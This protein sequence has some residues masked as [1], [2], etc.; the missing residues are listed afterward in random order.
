MFQRFFD[1]PSSKRDENVIFF[2]GSNH[3]FLTF[4]CA[5]G[6][7]RTLPVLGIYLPMVEMSTRWITIIV[8][9]SHCAA[10]RSL[11]SLIFKRYKKYENKATVTSNSKV[12]T[13]F[14]GMFKRSGNTGPTPIGNSP[15]TFHHQ[16][17]RTSRQDRQDGDGMYNLVVLRSII[18]YQQS[19]YRY[20]MVCQ[21]VRL[22]T[23]IDSRCFAW[24]GAFKHL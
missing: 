23:R 21:Y 13:T 8:N 11:T 6:C 2:K 14:Y 5:Q 22:E 4:L 19:R 17:D 9:L 16:R 12:H 20:R 1:F 18:L 15:S 24:W 10:G 3:H 7:G